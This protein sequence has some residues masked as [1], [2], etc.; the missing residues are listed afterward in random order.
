MRFSMDMEKYENLSSL[1]SQS[2]RL[3]A[4]FIVIS[5]VSL[6]TE[7]EKFQYLNKLILLN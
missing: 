5:T 4:I 2:R 6:V 3:V 1:R 7:V